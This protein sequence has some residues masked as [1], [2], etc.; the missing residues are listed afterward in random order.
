MCTIT[1]VIP[2]VISV[3][4]P[5]FASAIAVCIAARANITTVLVFEL[6]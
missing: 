4:V 5:V 6:S 2:V 3:V 1:I